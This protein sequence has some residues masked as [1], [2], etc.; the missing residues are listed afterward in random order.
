[1]TNE[2]PKQDVY[3]MESDTT[4]GLKTQHCAIK[5]NSEQQIFL[6]TGPFSPDFWQRGTESLFMSQASSVAVALL[7]LFLWCEMGTV[8][9]RGRGTHC[10]VCSAQ[11]QT[12]SS[13]GRTRSRKE[14]FSISTDP[15]KTAWPQKR[16]TVQS[17]DLSSWKSNV[18]RFDRNS[19]Q[20][21]KLQLQ[22]SGIG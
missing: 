19:I 11:K 6:V 13:R 10:L 12:V 3:F 9:T 20:I 2:I 18:K 1:M 17:P 7:H 14:H 21:C 5:I 4:V 22:P 16:F 15:V 8:P